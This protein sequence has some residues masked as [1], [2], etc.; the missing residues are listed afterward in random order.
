MAQAKIFEGTWE[1][2]LGRADEFRAVP[3]LTLIVPEAEASVTSRYR[4]DLTPAERIRRLDALAERY[5]ADEIVVVTITG[6]Y[7][8]RERSYELL[9][10]ACA[11]RDAA[12]AQSSSTSA[13]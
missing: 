2:L 10:D 6:D 11:L 4:S 3:K 5:Q 7:A 12:P 13:A 9:A 1:E 8:S